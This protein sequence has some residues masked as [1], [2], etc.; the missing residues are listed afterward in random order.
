MEQ[1]ENQL[2]ILFPI[3]DK[4]PLK[5]NRLYR[6]KMNEFDNFI[7]NVIEQRKKDLFK[8]NY[9]SKEKNE[10]ENKDLLMSMLEMSEK[11]GIKID[12]H[13]LR[14]NLVNF[15][16]AGHDTTSLNISVSIFHLAKYPEMQKKAREEVIRVLG[17]GLKIPTSEQIK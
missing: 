10:N 16:I 14:D 5:S 7:L 4:L 8:L 11:E 3:L 6:E 12:S 1:T 13:E 9:Q 2:H 15:F 17:D